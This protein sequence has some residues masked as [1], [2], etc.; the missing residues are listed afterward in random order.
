[1]R[2]YLL[3]STRSC[4]FIHNRRQKQFQ[5]RRPQ[6]HAFKREAYSLLRQISRLSLEYTQGSWL[7]AFG[8]WQV[9][10]AQPWCVQG[11]PRTAEIN[12]AWVRR[13][14]IEISA[15]TGAL[16]AL[17]SPIMIT[18][19]PSCIPEIFPYVRCLILNFRCEF[20]NLFSINIRYSRVVPK[21]VPTSVLT[22]GVAIIVNFYDCIT[23]TTTTEEPEFLRRP[24]NQTGNSFVGYVFKTRNCSRV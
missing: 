9:E 20:C 17:K 22:P 13:W 3:L 1:M 18:Y 6:Q 21:M 4:L 16:V 24:S 19:H 11:W 10:R 7:A 14:W 2:L 5:L 23:E 12:E 8:Y 15:L